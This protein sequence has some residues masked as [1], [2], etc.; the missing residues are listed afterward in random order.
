MASEIRVNQIQSRTGVSTVSFTDTGPIVSGV[1]T[2]QGSLD[3]TGGRVGIG[4]DV[5]DASLHIHRDDVTSYPAIWMSGSIKEK[6]VIKV[7]NSDNLII[8]VDEDNEGNDSN[9]R[10][11][12]DGSEKIR[13]TSAGSVGIASAIPSSGFK[14]DVN[15]DLSLGEFSG[16]DNTYID[17]KQNGQLNIINSGRQSNSGGVRI[18]KTNSISG[19]TTYFRDF[20]VYDG[21]DKLLFLIDGSVVALVSELIHLMMLQK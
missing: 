3:V 15:G 1:T 20:E 14:L 10:L 21:K 18:N 2:V 13:V 6:N 11:Q 12:I 5:P 17:Q 8:S 7:N 16:S 19:D 9:F 4:T